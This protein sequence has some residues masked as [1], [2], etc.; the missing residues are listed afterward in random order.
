MAR[1]REPMPASQRQRGP[2]SAFLL[3]MH[4]GCFR[5]TARLQQETDT[6]KQPLRCA[7]DVAKGEGEAP[8]APPAKC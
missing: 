5:Q 3:A 8:R 2:T 7:G 1:S 4:H 6:R